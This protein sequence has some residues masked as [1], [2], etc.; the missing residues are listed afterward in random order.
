MVTFPELR[1]L[2]AKYGNES[3]ANGTAYRQHLSH[4]WQETEQ[5]SRVYL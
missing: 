4:L 2:M 1:A 5:Q 3:R